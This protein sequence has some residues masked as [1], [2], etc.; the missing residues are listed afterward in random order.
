MPGWPT[1][2]ST[3]RSIS[4][5]VSDGGQRAEHPDRAH[6]AGQRVEETQRDGR[7]S[8]QTFGRGDVHAAAHLGKASGPRSA[9]KR[10]TIWSPSVSPNQEGRT[11]AL[12]AELSWG[13]GDRTTADSRADGL[14]RPRP[15]RLRHGVGGPAGVA[16]PSGRGEGR[17]AH[18]RFGD[19]AASVPPRGRRGWPDVGTPGHRHRARRRDPGRRPA[20]PG[21]AVVSGRITD[22]MAQGCRAAQ[23]G[24][25]SRGRR[26]GSPTPW[27][28]PTPAACCTATSSRPTS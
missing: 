26:R 2:R 27:R 18:P 9:P 22:Q 16:E 11:R 8:G 4:P 13:S 20:L 19:R 25:G 17:S 1:S 15:G 24:A 5:P 21:H 12:R 23:P 7:L 28:P 6:L 3:I 14:A 10:D